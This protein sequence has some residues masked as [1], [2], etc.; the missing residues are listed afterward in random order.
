MHKREKLRRTREGE[1]KGRERE[2]EKEANAGPKDSRVG[3]LQRREED[4]NRAKA[5]G[6]SWR[7]GGKDMTTLTSW[8]LIWICIM[9]VHRSTRARMTLL[10]LRPVA[11]DWF[12]AKLRALPTR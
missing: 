7:E 9:V 11:N 2:K 10:V 4:E 3:G 1:R 8:K 12:D 5:D 6:M